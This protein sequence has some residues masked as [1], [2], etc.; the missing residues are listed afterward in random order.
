M[1]LFKKLMKIIFP[2]YYLLKVSC[3]N[4]RYQNGKVN[5]QAI[6]QW[7]DSL[8]KQCTITMQI[9][10]QSSVTKSNLFE[11]EKEKSLIPQVL[12]ENTS[13]EE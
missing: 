10:L 7:Y 6:Q 3:L 8:Y 4:D 11:W 1:P 5:V 13:D 9:D 12:E 2:W